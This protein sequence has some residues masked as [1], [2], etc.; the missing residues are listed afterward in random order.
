MTRLEVISDVVCPWCYLGVAQLLRALRDRGDSLFA[1]S[2]KPYQLDP[3]IPPEGRDRAAH[4]KAKFGDLARLAPVH[5]RLREAGRAVGLTFDFAAIRRAPNTLDAHRVIRWAAAEGR[6]T[7][8]ALEIFRRYFEAGE[9][10]SDPAVLA[11]AAETAGLDG[12]AIGRLLAGDADRAETLA[13]AEA[14]RSMGVTGVPTFLLGGRYAVV[15]AQPVETWMRIADEIE[16]A[17]RP[18]G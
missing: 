12:A 5:D 1:I 10:V 13:E 9:D 2:W 4:M 18:A 8:T 16:S 3:D 11:A 6:Q 14:A 15:G 7:A 17:A